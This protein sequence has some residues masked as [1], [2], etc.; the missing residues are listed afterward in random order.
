[1]K[2]L[3]FRH[4]KDLV[5]LHIENIIKIHTHKYA[6]YTE[7]T[8]TSINHKIVI[9]DHYRGNFIKL[10][11][12]FIESDETLREIKVTD[13]RAQDDNYTFFRMLDWVSQAMGEK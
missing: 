11:Y 2:T 5:W 1:M 13:M 7:T 4:R 10:L 6:V 9:H 3:I 8:I 12:E